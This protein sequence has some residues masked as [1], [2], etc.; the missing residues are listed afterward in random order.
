MCASYGHHY[1]G[2]FHLGKNILNCSGLVP[3]C[4][5]IFGAAITDIFVGPGVLSFISPSGE[6]VDTLPESRFD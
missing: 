2:V 1:L 3:A 6:C 4:V 5:E